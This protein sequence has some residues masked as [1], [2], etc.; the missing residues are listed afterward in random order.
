VPSP[1]IGAANLRYEWPITHEITGSARI[2]EIVHSHNPGPFTELDPRA[3][4]YDPRLAGDPATNVLNLKL[5]I[6]WSKLD[7]RLFVNNA[8]DAHPLLQS[9]ADVPG[10][11]P[12]YAHTLTPRTWGLAGAWSF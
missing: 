5:G 3:I 1:W 10:S 11:L 9:L 8:L 7:L 2:D 12:V 4:G 6:I